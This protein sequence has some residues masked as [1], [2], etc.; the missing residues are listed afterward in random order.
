MD[1]TDILTDLRSNRIKKVIVDSDTANEMDDQ[2][3]IAYAIALDKAKKIDLLSIN[4]APF[5]NCDDFKDKVRASYDEIVR[6]LDATETFGDYPVYEGSESSITATN[7]PID[8]PAAQNIIKTA[9]E[10]DELVY[11]LALGACT[12][13]ASAIMLEPSIKEKIC[14]V[15]LAGHTFSYG[16]AR[17]YNI[18]QDFKAGQYLFDSGVALLQMPAFGGGTEVL[19]VTFIMLE[20]MLSK[21]TSACKFFGR[22]LPG[23]FKAPIDP[24][25]ESFEKNYETWQRVLWDIAAPGVLSHPEAFDLLIV[26]TPV[27][28]DNGDYI[29]DETRHKEIYMNSVDPDVI[30]CDALSYIAGL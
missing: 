20:S 3:A 19:K 7:A 29:F 5:G 12:N 4:A 6:I 27:I 9:L 22:Q 25:A 11:I 16:H 30:V 24:S 28:T 21:D 26:P 14:V 10:S 8:S 23:E 1:I 13:I 18:N 2:Y 15:W 17:E